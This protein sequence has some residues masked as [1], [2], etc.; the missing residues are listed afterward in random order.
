MTDTDVDGETA[1]HSDK[2]ARGNA[3]QL[4]VAGELCR[5][6]SVALVTVGDTPNTD[7]L[8]SSKEGANVF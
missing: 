5:R 4:F 2:S 1:K 3:S 6:E 7:I 8:A